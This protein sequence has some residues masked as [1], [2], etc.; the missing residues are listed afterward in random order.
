[1]F[2]EEILS[3]IEIRDLEMITYV[4]NIFQFRHSQVKKFSSEFQARERGP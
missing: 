1:M 2:L 4:K 3:H